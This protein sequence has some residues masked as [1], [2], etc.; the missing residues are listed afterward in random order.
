MEE[1]AKVYYAQQQ[2]L[3]SIMRTIPNLKKLGQAKRNHGRAGWNVGESVSAQQKTASDEK[4]C[5]HQS[6]PMPPLT[7]PNF[8]GRYDKWEMFRDRFT[9]MVIRN[10]RLEDVDR[11]NYLFSALS[12]KAL[13]AIDRLD[14]SDT[15]FE[16][17]WTILKDNF[18][19][20][21]RNMHC[22]C[23]L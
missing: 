9:A 17:V 10:K 15:N 19:H 20:Q 14:V 7:L 8:D 12:G 4:T 16:L 5:S 18:E 11:M 6:V 3:H 21:K 1:F 23:P 22:V 13:Q 2:A